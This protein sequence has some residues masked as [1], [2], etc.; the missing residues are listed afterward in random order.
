MIETELVCTPDK[1]QPAIVVAPL[2]TGMHPQPSTICLADRADPQG[3]RDFR[4]T[5]P[6]APRSPL[7]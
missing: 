4:D 1:G 7:P 6:V 3:I 2:A 5:G